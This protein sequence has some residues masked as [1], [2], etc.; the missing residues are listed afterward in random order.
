M[1]IPGGPAGASAYPS[2]CTIS[3]LGTSITDVNLVLTGLSHTYPDDVDMLLVGPSGAN[4]IVM[5]DAGAG[6]DVVNVNV[7]LDDE[8]AGPLLDA[9]Q[10]LSGSYRP[11]NYGTGDTWPAPAPAPGGSS[12]LSVFDGTNPNGV[13]NLY[14]YDDE[15]LDGGS[16]TNWSLSITANPAAPL[17]ANPMF[18]S[19]ALLASAARTNRAS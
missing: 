14:I 1:T 9:S 17:D 6:G 7:T 8:A 10:I 15:A 11:A 5:S 3:G 2:T 4:A 19:T 18:S 16:L 13:W 12:L